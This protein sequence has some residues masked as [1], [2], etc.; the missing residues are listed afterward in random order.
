M[1]ML[2]ILIVLL[3]TVPTFVLAGAA[4]YLLQALRLSRRREHAADL[5]GTQLAAEL[6]QVKAFAVH[7][8]A[9]VQHLERC[10]YDLGCE[11]YGKEAVDKAI[12]DAHERGLN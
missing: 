9:L 6:E 11:L 1:P 12:R 5:A 3:E 2:R 7:Q 4:I 10:N 8:S